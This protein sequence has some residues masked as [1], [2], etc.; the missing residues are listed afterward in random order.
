MAGAPFNPPHAAVFVPADKP[1][2]VAKA[3]EQGA[4]ALIIDLE[5]AIAPENK[6][7]ARHPLV[8]VWNHYHRP[9]PLLCA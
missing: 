4:D 3:V 7:K 6:N 5:D 8:S 2:L 9:V 1:E